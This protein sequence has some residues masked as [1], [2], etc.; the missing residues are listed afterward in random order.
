M[1]AVWTAKISVLDVD[2]KTVSLSATVVDG[3][4][5]NTYTVISAIIDTAGSK[6]AVMQ[7]IWDQY[8]KD[9]ENQVKIET[10]FGGLEDDA[11]EWL[12]GKVL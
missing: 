6:L 10:M 2:K 12:E 11:K 1:A 5:T 4:Y 3:D 7:N 9:M 8:V